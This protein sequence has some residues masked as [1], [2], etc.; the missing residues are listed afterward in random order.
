MDEERRRG[1]PPKKTAREQAGVTP[2][3]RDMGLFLWLEKQFE[4]GFPQHIDLIQIDKAGRLH[5]DVVEQKVIKPNNKPTREELTEWSNAYLAMAQG[6]CDVLKKEATYGIFV[7]DNARGSEA[8]GRYVFS[9]S[10]L[11]G[12]NKSEKEA[13]ARSDRELLLEMMR[14]SRYRNSEHALRSE[15]LFDK[16]STLID[17]YEVRQ[18]RMEKIV[19]G[20]WEKMVTMMKAT[21]EMLDHS[22]ERKA[23]AEWETFKQQQ[24]GE[25]IEVVKM[26]IPHVS[27]HL[28]KRRQLAA[29]KPNGDDGPAEENPIRDFLETMN[30]EQINKAFGLFNEAKEQVAEGIFKLEQAKLFYT[31]AGSK[32][33]N[34]DDVATLVASIT[35]EQME[36]A[37]ATFD[38]KVLMP[39]VVY[40]N[41]M[42]NASK[43]SSTASA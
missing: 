8:Y 30:E 18:T 38:L 2:T 37:R 17:K 22:A 11:D 25:G 1:R 42:R 24:I 14:D 15:T 29:G 34:P 31:L 3:P 43:T 9:M 6:S 10:P 33:I 21:E 23:K 19:E 5:G 41:K 16:F 27:E 40:V 7:F 13:E 32:K 4:E 39:L 20:T 26:L 28:D 12:S 35:P 36:A